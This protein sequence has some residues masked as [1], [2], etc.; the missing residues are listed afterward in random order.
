MVR[1]EAHNWSSVIR[2]SWGLNSIICAKCTEPGLWR[3]LIS[4]RFDS[5]LLLLFGFVPGV[6]FPGGSSG[7]ESTCQRKRCKRSGFDLW[8]GK[9]RW[10]RAWQPTAMFLIGKSRGQGSLVRH[11]A[12]NRRVRHGWSD[13]AHR[14]LEQWKTH[15]IFFNK[16]NSSK[17]TFLKPGS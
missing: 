10:R 4:V 5:S 2:V 8:A 16:L 9:I 11:N 17:K 6:G 1:S 13:L 14:H 7:K 3:R 12:W 15:T